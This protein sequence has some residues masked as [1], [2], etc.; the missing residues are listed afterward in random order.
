MNLLGKEVKHKMF[1][2]G[3]VQEINNNHIKVKFL[4]LDE[5]KTFSYPGAFECFLSIK[6]ENMRNEMKTIVHEFKV[7]KLQEEKLIRDQRIA[8]DNAARL[9]KME[10]KKSHKKK[11]YAKK[12]KIS[13]VAFKFNYREQQENEDGSNCEDLFSDDMMI[14]AIRQAKNIR[15]ESLAVLTT[16]LSNTKDDERLIMAVF[17]VCSRND[18][19]DIPQDS[20]DVD[21][22]YRIQLSLDEAKQVK[23]WDYYFNPTN[24]AKINFGSGHFRYLTDEQSAQILKKIAEVKKNTEE[25]KIS[26][27]FYQYYCKIKNLD[28]NNIPEPN[29][30]LQR[31]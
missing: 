2:T 11:A 18:E 23:F 10:E 26:L 6:D 14:N 30:A 1:G 16:R 20:I 29:G 25:E 22:V 8:E 21:P 27:D 9:V 4:D 28:C 17:M 31:K 24:A 19:V 12:I 13:N 7:A 15:A 3:R 5:I